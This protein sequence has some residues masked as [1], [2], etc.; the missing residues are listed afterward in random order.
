M[1]DYYAYLLVVR[2][3]NIKSKCFNTILSASK[4]RNMRNVQYDNGRV[5][6][7]DCLETTITDVDFKILLK[8][9]D[10]KYE[11][12]ESYCSPY[13]YLPK[14]FINF[15]LDKYVMKTEYKGV[16]GKELEYQ[17]EKS[18]FNALYGMAVTCNIKDKVIFD[19]KFKE[20]REEPISNDEILKSLKDEEKEGFLSESFGVWCTSIARY[21]LL[22]N[23]Y[24]LDPYVIYCD[25]DSIRLK[26]GYDKNVIYEYN[27]KVKERIK[28]VSEILKIP[29]NK[30]APKD[31][32]GRE[33]LIGLF[34]SETEFGE[35][36]YLEFCTQGAKKYAVRQLNEEGKEELHIT[37]SGVPKS[38]VVALKGDIKNFKDYLV[39]KSED[40][41]KQLLM[42]CENQEK[43]VL[44]DYLGNSKEVNDISGCCLL[45]TTY[46]LG[47]S[48]DYA[49]LLLENHAK[50]AV[51]NEM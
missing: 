22:I 34:D 7:A 3:K 9:Y 23:V 37:V 24:K 6:S 36:T 40:T 39:F 32:K 19:D 15:C 42:Y 17:K 47:K 38:G 2:F 12:L 8:F 13:R 14:Q 29:Y 28:K 10:C 11:I 43:N 46:V 1:I 33:R 49:N 27:E 31:K 50:R 35:Y 21:N 18:K 30:Y 16:P 44:T 41:N 48:Q 25:T 26:Q 51:Y 45:P 4:C 20:W 5:I